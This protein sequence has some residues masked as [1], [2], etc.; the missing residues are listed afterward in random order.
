M[1]YF[2]PAWKQRI[3]L[4]ASL[5]PVESKSVMDL[6][7]GKM[8]LKAFL[9]EAVDYI[10]VDYTDRGAGT[11]VCD[12]NQGE[13]PPHQADTAFISGCLEY[14]H[15]YR[16]FIRLITQHNQ[17]AILSYCSTNYISSQRRRF[18]QNWV[19][20]LSEADII[21]LFEAQNFSLKKLISQENSIF[22]FKKNQKQ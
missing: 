9:P 21:R 6:G 16:A 20:D 2:D 5:I 8:W 19:N 7:C 18:K 1:E 13:F 4:M 22:L 3:E 15:D 14:V 10:P 17:H 11:I 12:F